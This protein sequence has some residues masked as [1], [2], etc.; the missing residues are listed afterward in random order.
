VRMPRPRTLRVTLGLIVMSLVGLLVVSATAT[1][2]ARWDVASAQHTLAARVLPAR[3]AAADLG[4]AFVDQETGQR[5]YLLTGD[6]RLLQPYT[7]GQATAGERTRSLSRLLA[8]DTPGV[9]ALQELTAAATTWRTTVAE[10]EIAARRLGPIPAAQG[11]TLAL[12]GTDPFDRVRT[13]LAVLEERTAALSAAQLTRIGRA[14]AIANGVTVAAVVL[15]VVVAAGGALIFR[16]RF[17]VPLDRLVAQV[18]TVADGNYDAPITPA[19]PRELSVIAGSV[20]TMRQSIVEH[21]RELVT[22]QRDLVL[23]EEHDRMA[24]ELHDLTIQRLFALGLSLTSISLRQPDAAPA[25]APLIAETDRIIREVRAV[26]FDLDQGGGARGL[27]GQVAAVAEQSIRAL[28]FPPTVEFAGAV[29]DV[30][31]DGITK[32]T[33][34]VVREALSNVA[35][36]AGASAV[37]L[38]VEVGEGGLT[39]TV[40]DNGKGPGHDPFGQGIARMQARAELLGGRATVGPGDESGTVVE[41]RV[42]LAIGASPAG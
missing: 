28:G 5:G 39:V 31:D 29:D 19:G 33:V 37:E 23:R 26:I 11:S 4:K 36:H 38:R 7:E 18:R 17:G 42:P 6:P 3:Q 24:T 9:R 16:R 15:A 27:R 22:A 10:P 14:Q 1:M 21:G 8:G 25:L 35:R 12:D 34:A 32:G 2:L 41:W 40:I 20:D 13:G 30:V